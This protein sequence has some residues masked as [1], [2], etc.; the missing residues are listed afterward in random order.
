MAVGHLDQ[1]LLGVADYE[2]PA[3]GAGGDRPPEPDED[4]EGILDVL[5]LEREASTVRLQPGRRQQVAG[6][7]TE[8]VFGRLLDLL[9]DSLDALRVAR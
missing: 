4:V 3:E 6:A 7:S 2:P 5:E 9:K 8:H 1:A